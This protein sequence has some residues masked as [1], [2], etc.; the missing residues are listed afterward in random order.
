M[1]IEVTILTSIGPGRST[2][3]HTKRLRLGFY[4]RG[5]GLLPPV[6][7]LSAAELSAGTCFFRFSV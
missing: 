2:G 6:T 3:E 7:S 4:V 1:L 5:G